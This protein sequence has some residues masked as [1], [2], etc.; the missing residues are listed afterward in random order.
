MP[1]P[2]P[3]YLEIGI[4]INTLWLIRLSGYYYSKVHTR[5]TYYHKTIK[6]NILKEFQSEIIFQ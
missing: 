4:T 6:I 5:T 3:K 1:N 2:P